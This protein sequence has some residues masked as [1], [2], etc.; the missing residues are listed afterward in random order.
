MQRSLVCLFRYMPLWLGYAVMALVVPFY[1][2]FNHQGYLS[3]YR[4]GRERLY[5]SVLRSFVF[6]YANH[7]RFGQVILDRFAA[8]AGRRFRFE[9]EQRDLFD[10]LEESDTGFVLL[11]SHV[12]NYEMAGYSLH[13]AHKKFNALVYAGETE[14]MMRNRQ[15]ILS[16]HNVEMIP[17]SEDL[18]HLFR[19]SV[20]L[21]AGEIVSL[22]ADRL[23]GSA[24]SVSCPFFG[25]QASFP[26]GAFVLAS[27]K[28]VPVLAF[29]VMKESMYGYR[30]ILKRV[31]CDPSSPRRVQIE[32]L[33]RSFAGQL[34]SVVRRY[35]AQWFNYFDFFTQ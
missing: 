17:V 25:A 31:E 5:Y 22:P 12:G 34:E 10:G 24:K 35:P 2:L 3:I 30:V 6:V 9:F 26:M 16:S 4:F 11:S 19:M 32:Q 29:F 1:M 7:F 23:F 8:F 33:A 14:T 13:S 27:Q 28:S 15:R 18:S 21:D 20:A